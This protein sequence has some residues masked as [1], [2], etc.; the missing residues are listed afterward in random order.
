MKYEKRST[1]I[2]D[3]LDQRFLLY[4]RAAVADLL[5]CSRAA[6][7]HGS[8]E[9]TTAC[10][11][12]SALHCGVGRRATAL[13]KQEEK[14]FGASDLVALRRSPGVQTV[15][16]AHCADV[17]RALAECIIPSPVI[18]SRLARPRSVARNDQMDLVMNKVIL[19]ISASSGFDRSAHSR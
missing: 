7:S 5:G 15:S 13:E 4:R 2:V 11:R 6:R 16:A 8:S 18:N 10:P 12:H 14:V 1:A 19:I 17:T 3:Q 9:D